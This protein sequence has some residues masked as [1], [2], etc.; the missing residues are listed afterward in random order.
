MSNYT[1]LITK[2][3]INEGESDGTMGPRR[4]TATAEEV[5]SAGVKFRML[6]GDDE[7]YYEGYFLGDSLSEDA[8]APLDDFGGPNDGCIDI[9]Y[10]KQISEIY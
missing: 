3:I 10:N 7:V 6:D 9:Q 2:D 8:F 5:K 1:W 4:A